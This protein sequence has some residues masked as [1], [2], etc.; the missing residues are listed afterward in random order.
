MTAFT[1]VSVHP[2]DPIEVRGHGLN[3]LGH[4]VNIVTTE[5]DRL[6]I[7][8]GQASGLGLP[9]LEHDAFGPGIGSGGPQLRT[10]RD[11]GNRVNQ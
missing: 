11:L 4:G 2:L 6:E 10:G 9:S 5:P 3:R 7:G 8:V 1:M